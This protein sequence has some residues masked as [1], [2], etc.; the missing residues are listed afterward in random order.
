M[1]TPSANEMN[2]GISSQAPGSE[3][4]SPATGNKAT[5][6]TMSTESSGSRGGSRPRLPSIAAMLNGPCEVSSPSLLPSNGGP[7]VSPPAH[8]RSYP[9]SPNTH[10]SGPQRT[11]SSSCHTSPNPFQLPS[12]SL[13]A[14]GTAS[15]S[16]IDSSGSSGARN[17][18]AKRFIG[19]DVEDDEATAA[20]TLLMRF[21]YDR[22]RTSDLTSSS[23]GVGKKG[24]QRE[25]PYVQAQTPGSILGLGRI[26]NRHISSQREDTNV[27]MDITPS[28]IG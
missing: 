10:L 5:A 3:R 15:N 21:S 17:H 13:P 2:N 18:H 11:S 4:T 1:P 26:P 27:L 8:S 25:Q 16:L 9:C 20:A 22:N 19:R 7:H 12:S 23:S 14:H 24:F 6:N 28:K